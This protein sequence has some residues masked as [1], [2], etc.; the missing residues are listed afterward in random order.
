[1]LLAINGYK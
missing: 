1:K